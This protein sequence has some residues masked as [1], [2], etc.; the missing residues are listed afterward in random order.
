MVFTQAI[1]DI[2]QCAEKGIRG[3]TL[4]L[5]ANR[6]YCPSCTESLISLD[7]VPQWF[8]EQ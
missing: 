7:E 3:V 1:E 4:D 5:E 2:E 6:L 8:R